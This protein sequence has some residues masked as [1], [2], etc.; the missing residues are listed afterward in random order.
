MWKVKD[1]KKKTTHRVVLAAYSTLLARK[2]KKKYFM[3]T[4]APSLFLFL[5][6][7]FY[8]NDP[9]SRALLVCFLNTQMKEKPAGCSNRMSWDKGLPRDPFYATSV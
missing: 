7:L 6:C 4:F 8:E 2:N 1:G 5:S 3:C 9:L